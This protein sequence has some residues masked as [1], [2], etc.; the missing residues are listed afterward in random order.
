MLSYEDTLGAMMRILD[1]L[2][3]IAVN[4][5]R[6]AENV[7]QQLMQQGQSA[8]REEIMGTIILPHFL[9]SFSSMQAGVL[10][11][12]AGRLCVDFMLYANL[13]PFR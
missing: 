13:A 12:R 2:K 8:T 11:V 6:A 10:E 3:G 1:G 4:L 9:K 7:A 5:N